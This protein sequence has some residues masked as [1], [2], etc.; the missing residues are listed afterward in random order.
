M[1]NELIQTIHA[2][3]I[4]KGFWENPKE[5]GTLL[6]MVNSELVEALEADRENR[7]TNETDKKELFNSKNFKETFENRIKNTFEDELADAVIR[8]FDI[9]GSRGIDLTWHIVKKMKYN[10]TRPYKHNKKY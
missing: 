3:N 1:I 9:C 8:I 6:M 4:K 7:Y 2:Q 10:E 5:I